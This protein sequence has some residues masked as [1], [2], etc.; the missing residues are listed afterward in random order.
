MENSFK[1]S[2]WIS[3]TAL[4][5]SIPAIIYASIEFFDKRNEKVS[6]ENL[7]VSTDYLHVSKIDI[8]R[9][10]KTYVSEVAEWQKI[11]LINDSDFPI[12]IID[13]HVECDGRKA[14]DLNKPFFN[15]VKYSNEKIKLIQQQEFPLKLNSK[16]V[17]EIYVLLNI[18]LEINM[19]EA[20][21][22]TSMDTS[23]LSMSSSIYKMVT[24]FDFDNYE[25]NI[26]KNMSKTAMT[27]VLGITIT[28]DI[29]NKITLER[30]LIIEKEEGFKMLDE[31][32]NSFVYLKKSEALFKVNELLL[33]NSRPIRK[34][35]DEL[36]ITFETSNNN[37]VSFEYTQDDFLK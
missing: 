8:T 35:F 26:D 30:P 1:R 13:S 20:Y 36:K 17:K 18:P 27:E 5:F 21:L 14:S 16:E 22:L 31:Y 29:G 33:R 4:I 23:N 11:R 24:E 34:A 28:S 10:G 25:K 3:L 12:T 15:S 9:D 2:D 19:G 37:M 7:D 32:N 6:I